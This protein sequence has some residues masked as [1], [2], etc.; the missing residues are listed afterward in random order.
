MDFILFLVFAGIM[1]YFNQIK[2]R[3]QQK[4]ISQQ[5]TG[6]PHSQA[7]LIQNIRVTHIK[8]DTSRARPHIPP[9][10]GIEITTAQQRRLGKND[11]SVLAANRAKSLYA[12][13]HRINVFDQLT[14]YIEKTIKPIDM[15]TGQ[16]KQSHQ[17]FKQDDLK[18]LFQDLFNPK[19]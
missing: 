7:Q 14:Q 10:F 3:Q 8:S 4:T 6:I 9:L 5:Q 17:S 2:P 11:P 15:T 13:H 19:K 12:K 16:Q 1:F 18:Q